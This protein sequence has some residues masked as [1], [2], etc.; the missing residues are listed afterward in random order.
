[1]TLLP[2]VGSSCNVP[3]EAQIAHVYDMTALPPHLL[4]PKLPPLK[5]LL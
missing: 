1:M 4:P 2:A 3:Y 5:P